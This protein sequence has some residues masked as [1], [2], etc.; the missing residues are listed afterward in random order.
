[1]V[2]A[3]LTNGSVVSALASSATAP[4]TH[5]FPDKTGTVAHLD[6][7]PAASAAGAMVLLGQATVSTAVAQI[8][9][10]NIFTAAYDR[11]VIEVQDAAGS[12]AASL[13]M[14]L[15]AGGVVDSAFI[16]GQTATDGSAMSSSSAVFL[17]TNP[18]TASTGFA[19]L[20]VDVRNVNSTSRK[21]IGVRGVYANS[22][23][24]NNPTAMIREGCYPGTSAASGFSLLWSSGTWVKGTV[25]IYGIKNS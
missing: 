1:V 18:V 17:T 22:T 21:S 25:R 10:L 19:T 7:I 15:A 5:T 4:R 20:T 6:D 16:Y 8:D 23:A 2:K 9:F 13:L 11:Y 12:L 14:R 3:G 24:S